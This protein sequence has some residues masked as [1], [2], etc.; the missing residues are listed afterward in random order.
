MKKIAIFALVCALGVSMAFAS[1]LKVPWYVDNAPTAS[2]LP[3]S[4]GITAIVYLTSNADTA[5]E[6]TIAY[7]TAEGTFIGPPDDG[8]SNTFSI[9][10]RSSLAFR[11]VAADP[12]SG[13]GQENDLAGFL[14]PDRPRD[15][16]TKKNGS[17]VVEWTG[18]SDLIQGQI[19]TWD[20]GN[21][22]YAHL[23]PPGAGGGV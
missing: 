9:A 2:G 4:G 23:L 1:S 19:T 11:P 18:S 5:V 16:D 3:P 22:G 12:A 13:G 20:S 17:L 6:C 7:Y 14:V 10:A 8:V 15:V 21:F